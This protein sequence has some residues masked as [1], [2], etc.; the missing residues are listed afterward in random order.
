MEN[1]SFAMIFQTLFAVKQ[2]FM[3]FLFSLYVFL[4]FEPQIQNDL[5]F[6]S[7]LMSNLYITFLLSS[8]EFAWCLERLEQLPS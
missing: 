4:N 6:F 1:K 3:E 7:A 2:N 5:G 8:S